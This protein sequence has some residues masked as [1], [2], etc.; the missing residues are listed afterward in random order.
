MPAVFS[1]IG[2]VLNVSGV[3]VLFYYGMPY[4]VRTGD[5][6][7]GTV[8]DVEHHNLGL[9]GLGA[10]LIGTALQIIGAIVPP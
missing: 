6:G 9:L 2:L 7:S 8:L 4:R 5:T 1:I 10:V 3:L